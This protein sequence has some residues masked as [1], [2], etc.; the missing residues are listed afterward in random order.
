ML[1]LKKSNYDEVVNTFNSTAGKSSLKLLD[2]TNKTVCKVLKLN[3]LFAAEKK[4]NILGRITTSCK[5]K[6][7]SAW[8]SFKRAFTFHLPRIAALAVMMFMMAVDKAHAD[9]G[10]GASAISNVA[11]QDMSGYQSAVSKLMKAIAAAICVIGAFTVYFKMQNGDQDVKKTIMLV[12]GG[13][14]AFVVMSEAL[15]KILGA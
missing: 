11:S 2:F 14:I 6:V 10:A 5:R 7:K 4:L 1:A 13:C 12:V 3:S 15:P 8:R 9:A